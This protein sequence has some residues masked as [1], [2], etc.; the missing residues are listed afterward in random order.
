MGETMKT[1]CFALAAL[2]AIGFSGAAFAGEPT[3]GFRTTATGT[4]AMTDAELDAVSAG[5]ALQVNTPCAALN[6]CSQP[7]PGHLVGGPAEGIGRQLGTVGLPN[8]KTVPAEFSKG[9]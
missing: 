2:A 1:Y 6:E 9:L 7:V 3:K 8:G 4:A 5:T